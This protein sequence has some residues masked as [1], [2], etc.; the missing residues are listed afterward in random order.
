MQRVTPISRN[1]RAFGSLAFLIFLGGC[2]MVL[3]PSLAETLLFQPS[4][5]DPG[6]PPTLDGIPGEVLTLLTSDGVRIQG[7]WYD[8]PGEVG[9]ASG[10]VEVAAGAPAPA[11]LLLHGNAGDISHRTPHARGFLQHG[12]SVLLLEYRGYG[13]SEGTP[14][15]AGLLLDAQAGMD[16]LEERVGDSGKIILFGRSMGGA[17]AAALAAIRPPG[18]LV[19]ESAFTSLEAMARTLY[20]FLPGFL[21]RRLRG[22]FDTLESLRGVDSPTLV[23]HGT[24]DEIVPFSMGEDLFAG[25]RMPGEWLPIEGASHN[26]VFWV[27]GDAYFGAIGAFVRRTIGGGPSG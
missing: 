1:A 15:E 7:W 25:A 18:V 21:F 5:G 26:D 12:F 10:G 23:I 11:V 9:A 22:R 14:G 3:S 8:D 24:Q 4:R 19:L 20:P 2:F 6:P 13:G 17:V 27:G 16:F